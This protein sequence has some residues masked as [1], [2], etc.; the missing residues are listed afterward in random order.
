MLRL[1]R[2]KDFFADIGPSPVKFLTNVD[3]FLRIFIG[4]VDIEAHF[5]IFEAGP[6]S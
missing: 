2:F 1:D 5:A 6:T 4:I 3:D